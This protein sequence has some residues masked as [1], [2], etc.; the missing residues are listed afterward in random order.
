MKPPDSSPAVEHDERNVVDSR[1]EAEAHGDQRAVA[2]RHVERGP[3]E[4]HVSGYRDDEGSSRDR[5]P[6]PDHD[7][8]SDGLT[9]GDP[10]FGHDR[11]DH[12]KLRSE[13]HVSQLTK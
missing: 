12:F 1:V 9:R 10:A 11:P 8:H 2:G 7:A 6:V 13:D 5:A 3:L 4:L